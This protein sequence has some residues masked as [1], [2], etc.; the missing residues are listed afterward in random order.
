MPGPLDEG[1][2]RKH[3]ESQI[4]LFVDNLAAQKAYEKAGFKFFDERRSAEF[5]AA[6]GCP[7]FQRL[8][9]NL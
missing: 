1:R 2:C 4:T 8:T 3:R 5:Q 9:R 7:G 6:L